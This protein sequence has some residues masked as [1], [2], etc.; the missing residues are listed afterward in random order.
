MLKRVLVLLCA[1][2]GASWADPSSDTV[3]QAPAM[4]ITSFKTPQPDCR[5][6]KPLAPEQAVQLGITGTV[7][8]EYT[9]Y[10]DGHVGRV[11][12]KSEA[13][14]ALG[15]AVKT[16]LEGCSHIAGANEGRPLA[17]RVKQL[18]IFRM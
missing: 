16:W 4:V 1:A 13:H 6:G 10:A 11:N 7:Q 2:A 17:L 9:V 3:M 12:V 14:P 15:E 8:V 5:P 18:Y